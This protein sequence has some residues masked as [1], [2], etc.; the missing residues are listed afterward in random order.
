MKLTEQQKSDLAYFWQ[1]KRDRVS[2][3]V[4]GITSDDNVIHIRFIS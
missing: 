4:E 2:T 3:I 1:E